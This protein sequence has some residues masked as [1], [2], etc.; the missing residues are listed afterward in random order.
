MVS[1]P[2]TRI[3][4]V[5]SSPVKSANPTPSIMKAP[6]MAD[7]LAFFT[8]YM[9]AVISNMLGRSPMYSSAMSRVAVS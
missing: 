3:P 8:P 9:L 4:I 1:I 7:P 6:T 5:L 2:G